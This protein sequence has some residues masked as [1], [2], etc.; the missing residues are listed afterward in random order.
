MAIMV[1]LQLPPMLSSRILV[2]LLSLHCILRLSTK[3]SHAP[4]HT[5]TS[6]HGPFAYVC[7]TFAVLKC[8]IKGM[9]HRQCPGRR[10]PVRDV[11]S[12][13]LVIG[14]RRDD[15]TQGTQGLVDLLALLQ[16][17]ACRWQALLPNSQQS[18]LQ[19]E[20]QQVELVSHGY[21]IDKR[22]A[23][24]AVTF[25]GGVLLGSRS[26]SSTGIGWVTTVGVSH[27]VRKCG[28][29]HAHG[30]ASKRDHLLGAVQITASVLNLVTFRVSCAQQN[31]RRALAWRCK[32][33]VMFGRWGGGGV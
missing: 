9:P 5:Q 30:N 11:C 4:V 31:P 32:Q 2:S 20:C 6:P 16:P 15:V 10:Q 23:V 8:K 27:P 28:F 26:M 17:L 21:G 13:P 12:G 29:W 22:M 1:V 14:Q 25:S 33:A 24:E 3:A 18:S 7:T 19:V